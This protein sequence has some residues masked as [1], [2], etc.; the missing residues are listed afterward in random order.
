MGRCPTRVF[1]VGPCG[2]GVVDVVRGM[3]GHGSCTWGDL[4]RQWAAFAVVDACLMSP[5]TGHG[6]GAPVRRRRRVEAP[7]AGGWPPGARR[8]TDARDHQK[9][10]RLSGCWTLLTTQARR[11]SP[12]GPSPSSPRHPRRRLP[13][14]AM[15]PGQGAAGRRHP[16]YQRRL[17]RRYGAGDFAGRSPWRPQRGA[18]A[19]GPW[20]TRP[21][22][23]PRGHVAPNARCQPWSAPPEPRDAAVPS[24]RRWAPG[25]ARAAARTGG[26]RARAEGGGRLT[27][28]RALRRSAISRTAPSLLLV[29]GLG[30]PATGDVQRLQRDA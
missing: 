14:G 29:L 9:F 17:R 2:I 11:R 24:H 23:H 5:S 12:M 3:T 26:L 15:P 18:G 19:P 27:G 28:R 6:P 25:P 13:G 22:H 21:D 20:S 7:V 10:A 4:M 30:R 8:R 1:D 16:G